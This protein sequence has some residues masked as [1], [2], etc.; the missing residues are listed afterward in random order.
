MYIKQ[1]F[2]LSMDDIDM[3]NYADN[4]TPRVTANNI[5]SI[6]TFIENASYTS[7]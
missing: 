2:F 7:A 3:A 5:D 1:I 4:S 6:V